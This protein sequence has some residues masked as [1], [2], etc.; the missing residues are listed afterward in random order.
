MLR[1]D[2]K[3]VGF[4]GDDTILDICTRNNIRIP[5]LCHQEGLKPPARCRICLVEMDGR[6]VTSCSTKPHDGAVV[7]THSPRAVKGRKM[8]IEPMQCDD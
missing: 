8:N 5:T 7:E 3:D 6:L 2:G 4:E 1:L